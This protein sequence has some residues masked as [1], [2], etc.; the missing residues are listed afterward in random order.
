MSKVEKKS[1]KE[2]APT[3]LI[4]Y[5]KQTFGT[6]Q[7]NWWEFAKA[8][9]KIRE[10]QAYSKDVL[11]VHGHDSFKDFCYNEYPTVDLGTIYKFCSI[12]EDW[13]DMVDA[14]IKKD[15][16]FELPAYEACYKLL[17]VKNSLGKE[18]MSRLRKALM[19]AQISYRGLQ[20]QLK[21]LVSSKVKAAVKSVNES[22]ETVR[23]IEEDLT[24]DLSEMEDFT[25][26]EDELLDD[27]DADF[28]SESE[29]IMEEDD[30]DSSVVSCTLRAKYLIDNLPSVE[31]LMKKGSKKTQELEE[32]ASVLEELSEIANNFFTKY[33]KLK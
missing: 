18:E 1:S 2:L 7:R 10:E 25:E 31:I 3:E 12:V 33:E 11:G 6:M 23:K 22:E 15:P 14:R 32:L 13:A 19:D 20:E 29:D 16:E 8:I 17:S 28:D 4:Q 27:P 24:K 5:A 26:S 30:S 21:D 9:Y